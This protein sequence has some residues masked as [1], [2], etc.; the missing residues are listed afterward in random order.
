MHVYF[1]RTSF[2]AQPFCVAGMR[3]CDTQRSYSR[4]LYKSAYSYI[5]FVLCAGS[6]HETALIYP[7]SCVA[8]RSTSFLHET[9]YSNGRHIKRLLLS[10]MSRN[11]T[12]TGCDTITYTVCL[13]RLYRLDT[14]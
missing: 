4:V 10:L 8:L 9:C 13:A 6:F 2:L 3:V 11:M 12:P 1:K 14:F 5:I 7:V